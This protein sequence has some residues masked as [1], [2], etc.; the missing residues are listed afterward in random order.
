MKCSVQGLG[1]RFQIQGSLAPSHGKNNLF[2]Y[3]HSFVQ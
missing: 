3:K 2:L 1:A